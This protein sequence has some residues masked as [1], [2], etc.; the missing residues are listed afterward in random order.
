MSLRRTVETGIFSEAYPTRVVNTPPFPE[1][2]QSFETTGDLPSVIKRSH[3]MD[4][5]WLSWQMIRKHGAQTSSGSMPLNFNYR[6]GFEG[7]LV[8]QAHS[9]E[10]A[11]DHLLKLGLST[12]ASIRMQH[13]HSWS[14]RNNMEKTIMGEK[15]D[16]ASLER[17]YAIF[18]AML[19]R[20]RMILYRNNEAMSFRNKTKDKI[21][22][23]PGIQYSR[24]DSGLLVEE[25]VLPEAELKP[26][27]PNGLNDEQT[28]AWKTMR[29]VGQ[30]G[31]P[32]I[33]ESL[34][35]S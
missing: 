18:G 32:I 34:R 31:H 35:V 30:L 13:K 27:E 14:V 15:V 29:K 4:K 21:M 1:F 2:I 3:K 25:Y 7:Y 12:W 8:G 26:V 20:E 24:T 17:W 19:A 9:Q 16:L 28:L 5:A 22:R 10:E 6:T 33:R 11:F 23:L